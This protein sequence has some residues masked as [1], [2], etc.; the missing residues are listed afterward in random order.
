VISTLVYEFVVITAVIIHMVIVR[1]ARLWLIM[2]A[3]ILLIRLPRAVAPPPLSDVLSFTGMLV[4][5]ILACDKQFAQVNMRKRGDGGEWNSRHRYCSSAA[6]PTIRGATFLGPSI[7][8][9]VYF[10]RAEIGK[11]YWK[12]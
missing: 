8:F 7:G 2:L 9:K 10:D 12:V 5:I 4:A 3:G 1:V 6:I 11:S